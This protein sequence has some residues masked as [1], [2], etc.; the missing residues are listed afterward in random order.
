[1]KTSLT[2]R[3]SRSSSRIDIQYQLSLLTDPYKNYKSSHQSPLSK[4]PILGLI[5][6]RIG[7]KEEEKAQDVQ[8]VKM[9]SIWPFKATKRNADTSKLSTFRN[10]NRSKS[11]AFNYNQNKESHNLQL[12]L[13]ENAGQPE[14]KK[15]SHDNIETSYKQLT[16][17]IRDAQA[18][19]SKMLEE[20]NNCYSKVK[21]VYSK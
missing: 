9:L 4:A 15:L 7:S 5:K 6:D 3:H 1:M 12:A 14:T 19:Q 16:D 21:S 17:S 11:E 13:I 8:L 20:N 18:T 2:T 10:D